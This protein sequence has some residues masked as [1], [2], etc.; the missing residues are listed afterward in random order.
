MVSSLKLLDVTR[1][2]NV[3]PK[4]TPRANIS[5]PSSPFA[6]HKI[7]FVSS[8]VSIQPWQR[9][10]ELN[11]TDIA[12][13]LL[14]CCCLRR[15]HPSR[16]TIPKTQVNDEGKK[17]SFGLPTREPFLPRNFLLLAPT[18]ASFSLLFPCCYVRTNPL[19]GSELYPK[20]NGKEGKVR[21]GVRLASSA[22]TR[23]EM[24]RRNELRLFIQFHAGVLL[25]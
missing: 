25:L 15:I 6:R 24:G 20:K 22:H 12:F 11:K 18:R 23:H 4:S 19:D 16:P 10:G 9:E 17:T 5:Y 13:L 21:I 8:S 7:Y 14:G 2:C 1:G 3:T